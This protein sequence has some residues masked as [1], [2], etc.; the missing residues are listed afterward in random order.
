MTK[1]LYM[2]SIEDNYIRDFEAVVTKN[3]KNYICL[4]QTAFYPT[5]GG[6][7]C[8]HGKIKWDTNESTVTEVIKKG[9]SIKHFIDGMLPPVGTKIAGSIDWD[10]RYRHMKMHTAQHIISG[11]V[12]DEYQARTVGNQIHAEYSRVDFHPVKFSEKDL[13]S[14]EEKCNEIL[15]R[16]IPLFIY[17]EERTHL[18][19]RV[20]EQR[21]NLDLI[22]K[23]ISKL[24][25]VETKGF[26]VCPC[27]GTHVRNTR[28]VPPLQIMKRETKG[29]KR[30]RIIYS[31]SEK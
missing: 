15:G 11:I 7:P 4:D 5:G 10:R 3:K 25:I 19:R 17:D 31:L 16:N 20:D 27:A 12:Y 21:C 18:E 30:E 28:E 24:R 9:D 2:D 23:S 8:D 14:I 1:L 29:K 22:P 13:V 26:D 6:Q